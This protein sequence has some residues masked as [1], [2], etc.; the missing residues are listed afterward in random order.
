[1]N[2]YIHKRLLNFRSEEAG[3]SHEPSFRRKMCRAKYRYKFAYDIG[4]ADFLKSN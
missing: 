1:M 3:K 4:K 2:R